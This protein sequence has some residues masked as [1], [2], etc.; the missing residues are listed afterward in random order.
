M[1]KLVI[2]LKTPVEYAGEKIEKLE[3]REP[4]GKDLMTMP[5]KQEMQMGDFLKLGIKLAGRESVV[6]EMLGAQDCFELIEAV[7]NLLEGSQMIGEK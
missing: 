2:N 1:N 7:G 5:M 6:A 4:K 3:V